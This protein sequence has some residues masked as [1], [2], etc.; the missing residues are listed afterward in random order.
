MLRVSAVYE[1][2]NGDAEAMLNRPLKPAAD[3][4]VVRLRGLPFSCTED[5]IVQF[6]RGKLSP[7]DV[8]CYFNFKYFFKLFQQ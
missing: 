2:T 8:L 4:R 6:F 3:S 1:V 7:M 5:D